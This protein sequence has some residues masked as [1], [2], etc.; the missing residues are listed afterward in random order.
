MSLR[1][2]CQ[3]IVNSKPDEILTWGVDDMTKAV[4][5]RLYGVKTDHITVMS[6]NE[7][8]HTLTTGFKPN[9]SHHSEDSAATLLVSLKQLA[10]L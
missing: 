3:T 5:H 8:K 4:G 1:H 2:V 7:E 9:A 10:I 6:R